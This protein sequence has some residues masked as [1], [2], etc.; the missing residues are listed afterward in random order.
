VKK[1]LAD[2]LSA[3]RVVLAICNVYPILYGIW[4]LATIMFLVAMLTDALDGAAA[5]RW[6]YP[7][8][9][10]HWWRRSTRLIENFADCTLT[11]AN[12]I[13]LALTNPFWWWVILAS[14]V[15]AALVLVMISV[16]GKRN[17]VAA[18]KID[19][20]YGWLSVALM[21]SMLITMTVKATTHW[22]IVLAFYAVV[23]LVVLITK[24]DRATTRPETRERY[25]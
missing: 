19:V 16:V 25:L 4:P 2:G 22:P 7:P 18:E 17:P 23:G 9:E 12:L 6:P 14:V 21:A 5:R 3:L 8:E 11:F 20:V 13:W 15:V 1:Y 24:W 10:K